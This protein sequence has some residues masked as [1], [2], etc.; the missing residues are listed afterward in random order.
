MKPR[1]APPALYT[2][3]FDFDVPLEVLAGRSGK[4]GSS[5][6]EPE[7]CGGCGKF[8]AVA[9]LK[10]GSARS[11]DPARV[12]V[13]WGH[14]LD[15]QTVMS[16]RM[17]AALLKV[18]GVEIDAYPIG[19]GK[20]PTHWVVWPARLFPPEPIVPQKRLLAPYPPHVA[21]L[22]HGPKCKACGRYPE[23]TYNGRWVSVPAATVLAGIPMEGES[24]TPLWL[25]NAVVAA[26]VKQ[27]PHARLRLLG[28]ENRPPVDSPVEPAPKSRRTRRCT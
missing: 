24:Q 12:K 11:V 17:L 22:S 4:R 21:F 15:A 5:T 8:D 1:P 6:Y 18:P 10:A 14:T 27:F 2:D 25:F 13:E 23:V 16:S 9:C 26:A 7:R 28:L 20:R 3:N 19:P